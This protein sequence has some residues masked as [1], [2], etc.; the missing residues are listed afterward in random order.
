L[1]DPPIPV[2]KPYLRGD[3]N[4]GDKNRGGKNRVIATKTEATKT[5]ATKTVNLGDKYRLAI[6]SDTS[7]TL[8]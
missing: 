7:V 8:I 6:K 3:K 4:R 1:V 2:L 5:E